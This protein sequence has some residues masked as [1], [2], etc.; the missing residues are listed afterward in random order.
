MNKKMYQSLS[1][2]LKQHQLSLE[3]SQNGHYL[4]KSGEH[5]VGS[6]AGTPRTL[7]GVKETIRE[8]VRDG[9]LPPETKRLKF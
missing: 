2:L 8:L 9:V 6:F 7:N 1:K 4:I 3:Q 5:T